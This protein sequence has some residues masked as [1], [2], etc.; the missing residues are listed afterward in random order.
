MDLLLDVKVYYLFYRLDRWN[1]E[2]TSPSFKKLHKVRLAG[3]IGET[4]SSIAICKIDIKDEDTYKQRFWNLGSIPRDNRRLSPSEKHCVR[5][6]S[7]W[8]EQIVSE[9]YSICLKCNA[10]LDGLLDYFIHS[11]PVLCLSHIRGKSDPRYLLTLWFLISVPNW[12]QLTFWLGHYHQRNLL[13]AIYGFL[14]PRTIWL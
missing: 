11:L 13:T 2:S 8:N 7:Q 5:P 10:F 1:W 12:T 3:T 14:N 4:T 9:T 6:N